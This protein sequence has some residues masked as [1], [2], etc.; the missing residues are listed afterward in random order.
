MGKTVLLSR[1]FLYI[2]VLAFSALAFSAYAQ[3]GP[4][5]PEVYSSDFSD[6][7]RYYNLS[8]GTFSWVLPENITAVALTVSADPD[9]EPDKAF[10]PP[11]SEF[12]LDAELSEGLQYLHVQFKDEE[13]WGEVAHRKIYIDRTA[14]EITNLELVASPQH[15]G[16]PGLRVNAVDALSGV[17]RFEVVVNGFP[18][19]SFNEPDAGA[20][21]PLIAKEEGLYI[22]EVFVYDKAGNVARTEPATLMFTS[23]AGP[24][25]GDTEILLLF[26]SVITIL[27]VVYVLMLTREHRRKEER[28]KEE[29]EEVQDQTAKIFSVLR[30]DIYEQI[31]LLRGKKRMSKKEEA[32]LHN[33][34]KTLKVSETL[35]EKEVED[36]E[37]ELR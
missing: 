10:R 19:F 29:V 15:K 5:A 23:V 2:S 9:E 12:V 32:A 11:I 37:K 3:T 35:L 16:K 28:L 26:E 1:T 22:V 34:D 18:A 20:I 21:F 25:L 7:E 36:V 8:S 33:L 31:Q 27:L 6:E 30:D 4:D 17:D 13:E 14:P 24:L